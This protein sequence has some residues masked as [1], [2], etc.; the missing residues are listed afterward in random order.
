[1]TRSSSQNIVT[2]PESTRVVVVGNPDEPLARVPTAAD[3]LAYVASL[4]G[5]DLTPKDVVVVR[6]DPRAT[7]DTLLDEVSK[8]PASERPRVVV[9]GDVAEEALRT[10]IDRH[11]VVHIVGT[12]G[13]NSSLDLAVTIDKLLSNNVFG[14][15]RYF[16]GEGDV[17]RLR[18]HSAARRDQVIEWVRSYAERHDVNARIIYMLAVVADEMLTNALYTAPVD[19]SGNRPNADLPRTVKVELEEPAAI[20]LELRCDGQRL[21]IST[22][23]PFGSLEPEIVLGS[24]RR[25]F[26][27]ATPRMGTGGAGLGL[28]L[29]LGALS[30]VVFDVARHRRT[31]VIG[32]L[33]V[34]GGY[35]K[36]ITSGKSFNLFTER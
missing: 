21:G 20:E 18:C 10:L 24:L 26:E 16:D 5:V 30:H 2:A 12:R 1:M 29:L 6:W 35:K 14:L 11:E 3:E 15:S 13:P 31:E 32:L 36:L 8:M 17:A 25:C 27:R 34:S 4:D 28:Y 22:I 9:T 23:D 33:D 19:S 7:P